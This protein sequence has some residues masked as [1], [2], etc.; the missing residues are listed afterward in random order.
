MVRRSVTPGMCVAKVSN[1]LISMNLLLVYT[2]AADPLQWIFL[3][4]NVAG[5]GAAPV[6]HQGTELVRAMGVGAPDVLAVFC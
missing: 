3:A 5:V 4:L 6:V 2:S 1:P